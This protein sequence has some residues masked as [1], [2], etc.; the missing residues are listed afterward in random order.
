V[1]AWKL[2]GKAEVP[3]GRPPL[4]PVPTPTYE[5]SSTAAERREGML[6]YHAKCSPCHGPGAIGGG[7]GVPDLRYTT[8]ETHAIFSDIVLAGLRE[9][10]GTP[11]TSGG[12]RP[13]SSSRHASDR[14]EHPDWRFRT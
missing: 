3:P 8:P 12:C 5:V 14:K 1:L 6:V 2:G 13:G 7:S 4:G 10:G 11:P 9:A